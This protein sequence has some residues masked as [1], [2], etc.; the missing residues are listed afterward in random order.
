MVIAPSPP[1]IPFFS[2]CALA[3]RS[4]VSLTSFFFVQFQFHDSSH[5]G[6]LSAHDFTQLFQELLKSGGLVL[7]VCKEDAFTELSGDVGYVR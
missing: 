4:G 2:L 7:S 1:P 6:R 3:Y 5:R